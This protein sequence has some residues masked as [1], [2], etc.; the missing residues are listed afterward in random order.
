MNINIECEDDDYYERFK[1][2]ISPRTNYGEGYDN[3]SGDDKKLY[4][5]NPIVNYEDGINP[6]YVL[7]P[8]YTQA[9]KWFRDN[10]KLRCK[11]EPSKDDTVDIF[12]WYIVGWQYFK[13]VK[14]S[15]SELECLKKLISIVKSKL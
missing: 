2:E 6:K 11:F 13:N 7:A 1:E 12:I 10:L 3:Y 9:F 15:E 4:F 14:E 8:L 5:D